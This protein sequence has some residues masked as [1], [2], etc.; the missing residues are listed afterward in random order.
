MNAEAILCGS[1]LQKKIVDYY[2]ENISISIVLYDDI[3][4]E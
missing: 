4:D 1:D 2:Q 3:V